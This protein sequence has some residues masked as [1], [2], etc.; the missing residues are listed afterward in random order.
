MTHTDRAV[1]GEALVALIRSMNH[2]QY[3]T[4]ERTPTGVSSTRCDQ[5]QHLIK[6]LETWRKE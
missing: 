4:Y 6:R 3:R 2:M 1:I 5:W